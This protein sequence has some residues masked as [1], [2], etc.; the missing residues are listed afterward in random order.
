MRYDWMLCSRRYG[1][2]SPPLPSSTWNRFHELV[3]STFFAMSKISNDKMS[4]S[5]YLL[6]VSTLFDPI[7]TAPTLLILVLDNK[8]STKV[9]LAVNFNY[10]AR[11]K[12]TY[13][14]TSSKRLVARNPNIF[15]CNCQIK[16]FSVCILRLKNYP[17]LWGK[18]F[19][20]PKWRVIK[21]S[22]LVVVAQV[23]QGVLRDMNAP[24]L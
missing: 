4:I 17:L 3:G 22:Y 1:C 8:C 11:F 21:N 15:V 16:L 18:K 14:C 6:T 5:T 20:R 9:V 12:C 2:L 19:F 7:L 10:K 24:V 13:I 23:L